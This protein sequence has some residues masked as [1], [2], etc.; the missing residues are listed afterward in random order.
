MGAASPLSLLF[1]L[2]VIVAFYVIPNLTK[3]ADPVEE[4]P[5]RHPPARVVEP[6]YHY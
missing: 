3:K 5:L 4:E 6:V 1:L 2:F